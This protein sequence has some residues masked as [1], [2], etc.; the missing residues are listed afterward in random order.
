VTENSA[1]LY[2]SYSW[3]IRKKEFCFSLQV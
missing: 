2:I 3:F 1:V